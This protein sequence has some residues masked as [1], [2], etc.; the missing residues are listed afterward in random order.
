[1][2]PS[3]SAGIKKVR[4]QLRGESYIA[5]IQAETWNGAPPQFQM[6]GGA[7][8]TP[9]IYNLPSLTDLGAST[10]KTTGSILP[11]TSAEQFARN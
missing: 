7:G 10:G 8:G 5:L 1:M 4:A 11:S 3:S 2:G 9:M 6:T